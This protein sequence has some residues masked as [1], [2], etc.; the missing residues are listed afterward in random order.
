MKPMSKS[1][2][3]RETSWATT[4]LSPSPGMWR[5]QQCKEGGRGGRP[6][7]KEAVSPE[8]H[9]GSI[10][11]RSMGLDFLAGP[12]TGPG[13]VQDGDGIARSLGSSALVSCSFLDSEKIQGV[14]VGKLQTEVCLPR[15]SGQLVP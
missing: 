10:H 1:Q 3:A 15:T 7:P 14:A 8:H 11:P 6:T 4:I 5:W 12:K 2:K 13:S 9:A